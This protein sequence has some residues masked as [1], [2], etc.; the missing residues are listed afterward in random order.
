MNYLPY[1][2]LDYPYIVW[3]NIPKFHENHDSRFFGYAPMY[4]R[5]CGVTI[6]GVPLW[7][8]VRNNQVVN[9]SEK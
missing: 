5:N 4:V 2:T 9:R 8:Q 3:N 7:R 6:V 1:G